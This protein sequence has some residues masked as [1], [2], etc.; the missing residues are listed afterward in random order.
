VRPK[1]VSALRALWRQPGSEPV[2]LFGTAT[3]VLLTLAVIAWPALSSS[4]QFLPHAYC[5]T[6]EPALLALHGISDTLIGA[7]YFAIPVGLIYFLRKRPDIPLS[8][9]FM[10]FGTFIVACGVTHWLALLTLWYPMYWLDGAAK[11]VTAAASVPTAMALLYVIPRALAIPSLQQL[12]ESTQRLEREVVERERA[13]TRLKD[14]AGSLER[15]VA[16]RTAQLD[17]LTRQLQQTNATLYTMIESAPVGLA[18][19][20]NELRFMRINRALAEMTGLPPADHVGCRLDEMLPHA[21]PSITAMLEEVAATGAPVLDVEVRG[22]E[23]RAPLPGRLWRA[24]AFPIVV[25]SERVGIGAVCQEI[26][27]QKA[28]VREK[29]QLLEAERAARADAERANKLKDDLLASVS[30]ELRT[31]LAAIMSAGQVL[32][33]VLTDGMPR[34]AA[35]I[36]VRNARAQS[37]LVEDLLDVARIA[38]G[39][40]E[41]KLAPV[42]PERLLQRAIE[43]AHA[44]AAPRKIA[45][46]QTATCG[47]A[48]VLGDEDRL[49]QILDNLLGNAIKFSPDGSTIRVE[50]Q[51]EGDSLRFTVIDEGEGIDPHQMADLFEPF[52]Q[53]SRDHGRR[54]AG[55]GLGLAICRRLAKMHGG[56]VEGESAGPDQGARFSLFLPLH[57]QMIDGPTRAP[58]RAQSLRLDGVRILLVDDELDLLAMQAAALR[59]AGANVIEVS[60]AASALEKLAEQSVDVLV[61]DLRMPQIDGLALIERWRAQERGRSAGRLPAIALTGYARVEDARR[62]R[63]AGFDVHLAKPV[64]SAELLDAI[65]TL[66]AAHTRRN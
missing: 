58:D 33:V 61:S 36:I 54:R 60:S 29:E 52:R 16:E 46:E 3:L 25:A 45:I 24:S 55:L 22:M 5:L 51:I 62:A 66:I 18:L 53:A 38:A 28:A 19:W 39:Q 34:T 21:D 26:T 17:A 23:T 30:H 6:F 65:V 50:C 11:A 8:W 44:T 35:D 4:A 10:L 64:D 56:T 2:L 27:E 41:V 37:R 42:L 7:S 57:R 49:V 20:D 63:A 15:T 59:S 32:Q 13:E 31:P 40:L 9:M 1:L 43:T 48:L 14:I 12:Q 47:D